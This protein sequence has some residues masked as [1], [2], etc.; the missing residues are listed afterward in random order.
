[1]RRMLMLTPELPYPPQS[2]GKLKS[3]KLVEALAERYELTLASPLKLD[4][5]DHLAS[6]NERA[7]VRQ[8]LHRVQTSTLRTSAKRASLLVSIRRRI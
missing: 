1:M 3:M 6:Y 4:D 7:P 2:G 8:Q 5:S